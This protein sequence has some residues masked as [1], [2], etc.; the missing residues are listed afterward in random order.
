M[1]DL[2]NETIGYGRPVDSKKVKE[3]DEKTSVKADVPSIREAKKN[4]PS[5]VCQEAVL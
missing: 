1:S 5:W 4:E 2:T 3:E